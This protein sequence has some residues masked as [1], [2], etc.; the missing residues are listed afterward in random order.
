MDIKIKTK[1]VKEYI[2]N[3]W[4]KLL[5]QIIILC[6]VL[7]AATIF[8]YYWATFNQCSISSNPSNWGVFGDYFGGTLNP[9]FTL[10]SICVTIWLAVIVNRINNNQIKVTRNIALTQLKHEALKELR[11]ELNEHFDLWRNNHNEIAHPRACLRTINNFKANY[12]Y[13]FDLFEVD[14]FNILNNAVSTINNSPNNV[15]PMMQNFMQANAGRQALLADLG[16]RTLK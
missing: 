16:Q 15:T 12:D 13:L 10:I 4:W 9:L 1:K 7:I 3:N 2:K 8:Y 6:C 5:L 11:N 14:T